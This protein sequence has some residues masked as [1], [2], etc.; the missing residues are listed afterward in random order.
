MQ[1][2]AMLYCSMIE[3]IE[4][5]RNKIMVEQKKEKFFKTKEKDELIRK[6]DELLLEKFQK[7]E[8]MLEQMLEQKK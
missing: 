8:Q 2:D 4:Q 6:Y 7:L 3:L 1:S 5:K